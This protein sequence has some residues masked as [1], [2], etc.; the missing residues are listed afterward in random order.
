MKLIRV[1]LLT[2]IA[3]ALFAGPLGYELTITTNYTGGCGS[4]TVTTGDCGNPDTGWLRIANTGPSAFNGTGTLSGNAPSGQVINLSIIGV[5]A[6]GENWV[7]NA[8]PESS[9]QGGFNKNGGFPTPD[10]GLL[11]SLSGVLDSDPFAA[12]AFDKDIHSGVPRTNPYGVT[13]DNYVLQGGD[14][15]GRDTGDGYEESQ[16]PGVLILQAGPTTGT[17]EPGTTLL[18]AGGLVAL[19]LVRRK[20]RT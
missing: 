15:F 8:G 11:F 4:G 16:A 5:L 19:G 7:F 9:N 1:T 2:L 14:P 13:L 6:P 20:L 18:L 10:D 12:S 17:P 3:S